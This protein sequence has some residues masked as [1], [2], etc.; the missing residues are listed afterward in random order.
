MIANPFVSAQE[1]SGIT[2]NINPRF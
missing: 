1:A 2:D